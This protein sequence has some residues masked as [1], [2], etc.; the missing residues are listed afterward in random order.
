[1]KRCGLR[2]FV[3]FACGGIVSTEHF[4]RITGGDRVV[5]HVFCDDGMSADDTVL[6]YPN[7]WHYEGTETQETSIPNLNERV[8][9]Q[10]SITNF[11]R[12]MHIKVRVGD[13][14]D[15]AVSCDRDITADYQ[16]RVANKVDILL[17]V[18]VVSNAKNG[19]AVL[20]CYCLQPD[21]LPYEDVFANMNKPWVAQ[22]H[23]LHAYR[24]FAKTTED[25]AVV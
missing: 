7:I 6:S 23:W 25:V 5:G 4:R 24:P 17:D 16:T 3:P 19:C 1:M 21:A 15:G 2:K 12:V 9:I 10:N 20:A 8:L 22:E 14:Y 13:I 18:D 11:D